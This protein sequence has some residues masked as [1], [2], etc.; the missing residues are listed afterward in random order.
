VQFVQQNDRLT[1]ENGNLRATFTTGG[2]LLSLILKSS[3]RETFSGEANVFELYEDR[4]TNYDAWD[5]DPFHLETRR[6]CEPARSW[7]LVTQDPLRVELKFDHVIGNGSRLTQIVRLDAAAHRLEFHCEADWQESHQFLK[8]AFPVAVQSMNATYEMQFGHVERPTHYNTP[9]D[10]ARYEVPMHR[11]FDMSEH[12]FGVAILNDCKYG[13]STYDNLMRLSL[14]RAPESP[15]PKCDRGEHRFA[16]AVMPHAGNWR[17][18]GVVAEAYRFNHPIHF[19][20]PAPWEGSFAIVDD[21]NLL[22][23]TIKRA[24]DTDAIVLRLY[25]CHGGRGTAHID[26]ARTYQRAVLCN[27][28]EDEGEP[29]ALQGR[30]LSVD[31]RPHQII[32]IKLS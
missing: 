20:A 6:V 15:D 7:K 24:E 28:L 11:W 17:D 30:R 12:G 18:A 31:Y 8:V 22:L 19:G 27:I 10:L 21:S 29:L 5:V 32:S 2:R 25:E 13:G 4:P 26:L 1:L 23:D 3:G 9:Y 16:Y 14:L